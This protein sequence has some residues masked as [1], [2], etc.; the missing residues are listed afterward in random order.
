MVTY[1]ALWWTL[2]RPMSGRREWS[3][4]ST[5]AAEELS[6]PQLPEIGNNETG[7]PRTRRES[8]TM[9]LVNTEKYN[10]IQIGGW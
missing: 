3:G 10:F 9:N 8:L 5:T 1:T 2:E 6:R 7:Q 4:S